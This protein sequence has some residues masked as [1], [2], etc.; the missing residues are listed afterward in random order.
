MRAHAARAVA[1]LLALALSALYV[2]CAATEPS[3]PQAPFP[4][5][6]PTASVAAT[7]PVSAAA[8]PTPPPSD[9]DTDTD[10]F[11]LTISVAPIPQGLPAYDRSD[12]RHWI[13]A[14]RDCQDARQEA[15][16]AESRAPVRYARPDRCLVASGDWFGQ[17]TGERFTDPADLDIDHMVPLANAHR[18]GGW[19]WSKERKRDY[20]NDLSYPNHLIAVQASANRRKGSNGPEDWKPP[21]REYWCQYA[22]DWAAVKQAWGLTATPR[23]AAALQEML[24]NCERPPTLTIVAAE[25]LP[26]LPPT[27]TTA[28][29]EGEAQSPELDAD[30]RYD[31]HG[32]DRDCGDFQT[33]AQAQAFYEAAGG[34]AQD[35]H[36]LDADGDGI[37]CASLR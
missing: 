12:W 35:P 18:S 37:A 2:G 9:S 19:Q 3:L 36:R 17:Y 4:L 20:A 34:P 15:L 13:D 5:T 10:A 22:T 8:T 30:L 26:P 25:Y 7:A 16:I 31:P 28:A 23:E 14:D 33:H 32:P 24:A 1:C 6:A 27:P 11:A 29:P 21:R